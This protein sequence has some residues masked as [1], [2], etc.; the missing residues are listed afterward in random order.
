MFVLGVDPGLTRCGF[1]IVEPLRNHR[2]RPVAL[3][4]VRTDPHLQAPYR[5]AELAR[6]IRG[7][8]EEFTPKIVAVE[9]VFLQ[10]N[11]TTGIRVA[12]AAGVVIAEAAAL[13][14]HVRE[15]SPNEVKSAVGGHGRADKE[16]VQAM[17]QRLL[18]LAEPPQP[19]DVADAAALAL[20]HLAFDPTGAWPDPSTGG[21]LFLDAGVRS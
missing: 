5:L 13:G 6:E 4:V 11:M 3:G 21:G 8:I 15:Y 9:R 18:G 17:V 14:C 2:A 10:K 7:L 19:P 20:C 12:Q 1:A 16:M